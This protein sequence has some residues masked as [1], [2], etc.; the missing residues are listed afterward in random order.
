MTTRPGD[1]PHLDVG[2]YVL[3]ALPPDEEAAFENHLAGCPA[4]RREVEELA[5][6]AGLLGEAVEAR[7]PSP[8]VRRRVLRQISGTQQD[9]PAPVAVVH[10]YRRR[11][12]AMAV[13]LA[14]SAVAA[15]VLG[16]VAWR[17]SSEADTARAQAD[18]AREQVAEAQDGA[19]ALAGVV[20]AP[21][22]TIRAEQLPQGAT[23]SV[24]T[25]RSQNQAAFVASGLR[26][27]TDGRVYELWYADGER[28]RPA[29]LLSGDGGSQAH[30][31][32]GPLKGATAVGITVEPAGGS[33]QPTTPPLGLV[34]ISS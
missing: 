34:G 2:A 17:Q 3:H 1:D 11:L 28:F 31:L 13:S 18:T 4:C 33:R 29:G 24:I 7:A 6:T 8:E 23:A 26:P 32:Q 20:A 30:V 19:Q 16:G 15:A 27:L 22:A 25:S 12:R 5:A 9:R 14:A 10:R 21:D